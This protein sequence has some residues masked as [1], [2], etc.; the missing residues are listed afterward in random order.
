[1]YRVLAV[2]NDVPF[3]EFIDCSLS[4]SSLRFAIEKVTSFDD[5][6]D[7]LDLH[8]DF[9]LFLLDI[10]LKSKLKDNLGYELA[11]IIRSN[12]KYTRTPII[13]ISGYDT[14]I[15]MAI[16]EIHCHSFL[17]KPVTREKLISACEDAFSI[18]YIGNPVISFRNS[19]GRLTSIPIADIVYIISKGHEQTYQT[20]NQTIYGKR[21]SISNI[22]DKNK[23]DFIMIDR[24]IIVNISYIDYLLNETTELIN[25]IRPGYEP[26]DKI[27]KQLKERIMKCQNS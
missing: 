5:A 7:L 16:N 9:C 3:L 2:D 18:S 21:N 12:S 13:F 1:M 25:I 27:K 8:D 22:Y 17:N 23:D 15:P 14:V 26:T 24:G 4:A 20:V 11:R 19:N 6:I 10:A